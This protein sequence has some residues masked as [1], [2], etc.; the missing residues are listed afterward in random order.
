MVPRRGKCDSSARVP[1][2]HRSSSNRISRKF[3]KAPSLYGRTSYVEYRGCAAA[4]HKTLIIPTG[5]FMT[6]HEVGPRDG[7]MEQ[8]ELL[9]DGVLGN[10]TRIHCK[11][12]VNR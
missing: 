6:P 4:V 5:R 10:S 1:L 12:I 9:I 8:Y 7:A 2:F 3:R 11:F